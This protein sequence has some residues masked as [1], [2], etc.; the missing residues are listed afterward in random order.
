MMRTWAVGNWVPGIALVVAKSEF[1]DASG[2]SVGVGSRSE[3]G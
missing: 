2:V 3:Q 1:L